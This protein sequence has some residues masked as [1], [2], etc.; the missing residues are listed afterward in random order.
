MNDLL[1]LRWKFGPKKSK[2]NEYRSNSV[3]PLKYYGTSKL[4]LSF[5]GFYS[6][7]YL[8]YIFTNPSTQV[9]C[10]TRSIF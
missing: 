7:L 8:M 5:T 2:L 3:D 10:D 4:F 1:F 6:K 9:E